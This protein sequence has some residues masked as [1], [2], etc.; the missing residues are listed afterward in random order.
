MPE[1]SPSAAKRRQALGVGLTLIA[2]A[3]ATH[4]AYRIVRRDAI[5]FR[6]GEEA[7]VRQDYTRAAEAYTAARAAGFP[8][9][10]LARKLAL[11]LQRSGQPAAALEVLRV[12]LPTHPADADLRVLAIGLAQSLGQPQ[13]GLVLLAQL[14]PREALPFADL[15]RLADLYQQA[16]QLDEA[17]GCVRLALAR[18]PDTADLHTLLGQYLSYAGR[19]DEAIAAFASALVAD[20]AHRAALLALA[21]NL[22]WA[23]RYAES[24]QAYRTYLGE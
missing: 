6:A 10:S 23:R 8:S 7:F 3:A 17:I 12:H 15:V 9:D 11:A 22:A 16:G 1:P 2:L 5:A 24:V 19:R 14:G 18:E 4:F 13:V 21:R 20:P